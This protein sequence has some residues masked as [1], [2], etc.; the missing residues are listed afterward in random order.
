MLAAL[1]AASVS[2]VAART[3]MVAPTVGAAAFRQPLAQ[4]PTVTV[5][6]EPDDAAEPL[7][8]AERF[9]LLR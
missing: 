8:T 1:P 4:S 5:M 9:A 6:A 3:V 2:V 7:K